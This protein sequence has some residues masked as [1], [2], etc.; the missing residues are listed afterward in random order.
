MALSLRH[1]LILA[2]IPIGLYLAL[3]DPV[4]LDPR[5]VGWL[6]RGTDNGENALGLHA[7]LNDPAGGWWPYTTLL[8]APEGVT[9]LFTDSNPLV[10]LLLRPFASWLPADFQF[11]GPWILGCLLLHAFFAVLLLRDHAPNFVALWCG[12]ALLLLVPTLA[13][14]FIHA[15][16]MAHWLILWSLWLFPEPKRAGNLAS[17]AAVMLTAAMVHNYLLLMVAAIWASAMLERVMGADWPTRLRLAAGSL[18]ILLAV[19]L[20]AKAHGAGGDFE[21]TGSYGAFA[22][23]LDAIWNPANPGYS[24]FLPA[25]PQRQGRGFEGFQYLGLGLLILI[26]AAFAIR[27]VQGTRGSDLRRLVWLVP[28]LLV[29]TTL[30]ITP[31]VDFAGQKLLRLPIPLMFEAPLDMVRASGRLFWP[32]AYVL[33]LVAIRLTYRLRHDRATLLLASVTAL[34][35]LDLSGLL[36]AAHAASSDRRPTYVRTPSPRWD[37]LI[38]AADDVTLAPAEAIADLQLY[39]ELAWRAASARKPVIHVYAARTSLATR[40]RLMHA[41][42]NFSHGRLK[43]KRLYVL[44][45]GTPVPEGARRRLVRIDGLRVLAPETRQ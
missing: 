36:R 41:D 28:A 6:I 26:P 9:L 8:G 17:W 14:R 11:V 19:G 22:M 35:L 4:T 18:A 45:P 38:A 3:F 37:R 44:L 31:A 21:V 20:I 27:A 25:T 42:L 30:A 7:F 29:L 34:Q 2:L 12:T 13:N 5:A 23:S 16:L 43:P 32:V 10:A 1:W 15:N 24:T 33:V 39:Q 40:T